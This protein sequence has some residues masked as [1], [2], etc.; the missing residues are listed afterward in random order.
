M[1]NHPVIIKGISP[2]KPKD[3]KKG[4]G[5]GKHHVYFNFR[6]KKKV[7]RFRLGQSDFLGMIECDPCL[8]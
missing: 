3:K 5:G 6:Y 1:L 7:V 4:E 8:Q 2:A